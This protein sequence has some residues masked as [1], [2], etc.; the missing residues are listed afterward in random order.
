MIKV[1]ESVIEGDTIIPTHLFKQLRRTE[2]N[3]F[4]IDKLE[5]RIRDIT[6]NERE[7]DILAGVVRGNDKPGIISKAVDQ[8]KSG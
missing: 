4:N 2:A 8:S 6:L 3:T 7:Q 1:I 5:D